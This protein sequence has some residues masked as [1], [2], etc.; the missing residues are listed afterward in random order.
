MRRESAARA[1]A[2][3]SGG[4]DGERDESPLA[5]PAARSLDTLALDLGRRAGGAARAYAALQK[6]RAANRAATAASR[7]AWLE[8]H[9]PALLIQRHWRGKKGRDAATDFLVSEIS[10]LQDLAEQEQALAAE[11]GETGEFLTVTVPEGLG[12]GDE[13]ECGAHPGIAVV[14]PEG[15]AAGDEFDVEL[16]AG[17]GQEH[18]EVAEEGQPPASEEQEPGAVQAEPEATA[19]LP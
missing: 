7:A 13:M 5:Q 19:I 1:E 16:P 14:I 3:A 8:S 2:S 18:E 12:G 15:L 9:E 11:P 17:L 4:G 6:A 10:M